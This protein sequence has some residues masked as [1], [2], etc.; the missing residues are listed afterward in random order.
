MSLIS[1][2]R[3]FDLPD[4]DG[5]TYIYNLIS[6]GIVCYVGQSKHLKNRVYQHKVN[7]IDFN[8]VSYR[9]VFPETANNH[10]ALDIV[11][12]QAKHNKSLPKTD[13]YMTIPSAKIIVA[14]C[15]SGLSERD[16]C[17]FTGTQSKKQIS[18]I[19][20]ELVEKVVDILMC[21]LGDK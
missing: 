4:E 3:D 5:C 17:V 14:D 10:E 19:E 2:V 1:S 13:I 20:S 16:H 9:D 8:E 6:D 7:G 18:Y 11:K 12:Y 15:F 21:I